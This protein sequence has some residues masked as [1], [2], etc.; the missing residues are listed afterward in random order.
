MWT[1][2]RLAAVHCLCL[3]PVCFGADL[4]G[5]WIAVI[6]G[7]GDPQHT[8]VSLRLEG[9]RPVGTWGV[10]KV[11]GTLSGDRLTLSLDR[12][13]EP[14][15]SLI[16]SAQ[17]DGWAG[18]GQI[19]G[20][21]GRGRGGMQPVSWRL[22]R[23][24]QA[25]AG[26]PRTVEYDPKSFSGYYAAS[27]APVLRVFPGDTIRTRTYDAGGRDRE[28]R[29]PGANPETG[30]FYVEGALPGDTLAITLRKV[31]PNRDSARQGNRINGGTVTPA[32]VAA[33][34]Y[35]DSFD[36]EWKL[37]LAGGTARLARPTERMKNVI[38]PIQP[39]IG[40]IA[41]APAGQLSYRATDL[42]PY[43]GNMDYNRM[44][45][46]VTLYL[47]VFQPG[48]LLFLGDGHAAMGDGELT[49]S[50]LETSLDVEFTVTLQ[51]GRATPNPRL[52]NAADL[53][54]MGIAGSVPESIRIATA[55][56]A[57]WLKADYAL[58]DN[59]VAVLLGAVLKYDI[60]E[61]VDSQFNVVA[62]VPKSALA[63]LRPVLP[64]R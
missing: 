27:I 50:A 1:W 22:S 42:G 30:P 15:G 26:G 61:M 4:A 25:P 40:C 58:D 48:A 18:E 51:P 57:A 32:F 38:I 47:P 44:G 21:G 12:G 34:K 39:M 29:S 49:G 63:G 55:Q 13:G 53:M 54:A 36:S 10:S 2:G 46:S 62:R 52:E 33:A 60:A 59:E 6:V 31:R 5:D 64:V 24:P 14:A 7:A 20:A 56:L 11:E 28:V 37:D 19:R 16:G 35:S 8:R 23:F 41:T 17:G 3:A 43:G 45:E 9:G